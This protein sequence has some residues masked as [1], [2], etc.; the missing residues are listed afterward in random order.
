MRT[1]R[2]QVR[3]QPELREAIE[4]RDRPIS[5]TELEALTE[6]AASAYLRA[7]YGRNATVAL[8]GFF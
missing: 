6:A 2:A 4:F 5:Y 1:R 7:G 8:F 3:H